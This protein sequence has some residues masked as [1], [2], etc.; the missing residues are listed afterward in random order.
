[1]FSGIEWSSSYNHCLFSY[2]DIAFVNIL[3]GILWHTLWFTDH[4]NK[5]VSHI[6][7]TT[8]CSWGNLLYE[9]M[10]TPTILQHLWGTNG[11]IATYSVLVLFMVWYCT[12]MYTT[13]VYLSYIHRRMLNRTTMHTDVCLKC[14]IPQNWRWDITVL[15][16]FYVTVNL[17]C[18]WW[19]SCSFAWSDSSTKEMLHHPGWA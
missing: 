2:V 3:C 4:W 12:A 9:C 6:W 16:V 1:M 8:M 18:I 19:F 7:R 15:S 10:Y 17:S 14:L 5:L 13:L 11:S